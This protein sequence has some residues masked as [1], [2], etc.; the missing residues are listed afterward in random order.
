MDIE[1]VNAGLSRVT[2]QEHQGWLYLRG[3]FPPK[4][5]EL[6]PKRRR[7]PLKLKPT[8]AGLRAARIIAL[9]A[10]AKLLAGAWKWPEQ[11]ETLTVGEWVKRFEAHYWKDKPKTPEKL[12]TYKKEYFMT[13]NKLPFDKVLTEELMRKT[14]STTPPATRVRVRCCRVYTALAKLANIPVDFSDLSGG[15]QSA[16]VDVKTLPTDNDIIAARSLI[17]LK[18]WL[19]VYDLMAC[20]GLRNH[21]AFYIDWS[22]SSLEY[23]WVSEGKTG[24][25]LAYRVAPKDWPNTPTFPVEL[26]HVNYNGGHNATGARV[27]NHFRTYLPFTPYSLRHSWARRA[28]ERGFPADFCA[29][30]MGHSLSVHLKVYRRFWGDEPYKKVYGQIMAGTQRDGV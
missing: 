18:P 26:P 30:A 9:D 6:Q 27:T 13:F 28:F 3:V 4:P 2:L 12:N 7:I 5:G 21:E 25:R 17:T 16:A 23:L 24:S 29:K 10:E 11:S 8:Q 15:Y 19:H 20:Y 14:I 22:Q 1:Q